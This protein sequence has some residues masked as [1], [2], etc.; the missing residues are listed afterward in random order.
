M[1]SRSRD[2]VFTIL[3]IDQGSPA[4]KKVA[5][6]ADDAGSRLDRMG[7]TGTKALGATTVA[8]TA[9]GVGVGAALAGTATV[10][11]AAGLAIAASNQE[12]KDSF[13]DLW[14]EIGDGAQEAAEPLVLLLLG[15][16]DQLGG[17]L[18]AIQP[19]LKGLFEDSVP[20]V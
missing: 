6:A 13:G 14:Q 17:L 5:E 1:G 4:F 18:E 7:K 11:G 2:L 19:R 10:V 8:A 15:I 12:V 20:A 9:A 16:R 3:G